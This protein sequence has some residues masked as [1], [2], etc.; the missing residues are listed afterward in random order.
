MCVLEYVVYYSKDVCVCVC[1]CVCVYSAC[2]CVLCMVETCAIVVRSKTSFLMQVRHLFFL[3]IFLS[4]AGA[5]DDA[6]Q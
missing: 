3:F 6:R 4:L 2:V 1:V 5:L